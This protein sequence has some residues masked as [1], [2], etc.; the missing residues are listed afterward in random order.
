MYTLISDDQAVAAVESQAFS[1]VQQAPFSAQVTLT[2][3]GAN[4]IAYRFQQLIAGS[5]HDLATLGNPLNN[6]LSPAQTVALQADS[7]YPQ[8]RMLAQA[9]SGSSLQFAV[10]RTVDRPAGGIIPLVNY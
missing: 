8:V 6:T 4:I 10:Q 5:W 3:T 1:F 2:N 9:T 7:D